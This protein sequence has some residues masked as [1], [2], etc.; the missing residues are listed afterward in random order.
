MQRGTHAHTT[1]GQERWRFIQLPEVRVATAQVHTKVGKIARIDRH[2]EFSGKADVVDHVGQTNV[3]DP[4]L[5]RVVAHQPRAATRHAVHAYQPDGHFLHSGQVGRR[6]GGVGTVH[7]ISV[8]TNGVAPHRHATR[9]PGAPDQL[10]IDTGT[11]D[12]IGRS[13]QEVVLELRPEDLELLQIDPDFRLPRTEA[14]TGVHRRA[15]HVE[16]VL[17]PADLDVSVQF[18][19]LPPTVSAAAHPQA[20]RL[21]SHER[22]RALRKAE[23]RFGSIERA[24]LAPGNTRLQPQGALV[25]LQAIVLVSGLSILRRFD[26]ARGRRVRYQRGGVDRSDHAGD[27]V[28]TRHTGRVAS[29]T[30][31]RLDA[32][33]EP[34]RADQLEPR[35]CHA[36]ERIVGRLGARNHREPQGPYPAIVGAVLLFRRGP[37]IQTHL[38]PAERI[39]DHTI[40]RRI[41]LLVALA[42]AR[43]VARIGEI[44]HEAFVLFL[45][46]RGVGDIELTIEVDVFFVETIIPRAAI[47]AAVAQHLH[48]LHG[49]RADRHFVLRADHRRGTGAIHDDDGIG[50]IAGK[51]LVVL[52]CIERAGERIAFGVEAVETH[53]SLATISGVGGKPRT[54]GRVHRERFGREGDAVLTDLA[55]VEHQRGIALHLRLLGLHEHEELDILRA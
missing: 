30:G 25:H 4:Q 50:Y 23:E 39:A 29:H 13:R 17:I 48:D 1:R 38:H 16:V 34:R 20:Q 8:L 40:D 24:E 49:L 45:I 33:L 6:D 52:R 44:D 53:Q 10:E 21:V 37:P 35:Q 22:L 7:D 28:A 27:H 32:A 31:E 47:C 11:G 46:D 5:E 36:H 3:I 14:G 18:A 51:S 2:S 19:V 41:P 15:V 12:R 55:E 54:N 42:H 9:Q 26:D 43:P